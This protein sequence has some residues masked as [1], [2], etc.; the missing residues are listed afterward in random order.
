MGSFCGFGS[1]LA[2]TQTLQVLFDA[3]RSVG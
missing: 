1:L 3:R 2:G